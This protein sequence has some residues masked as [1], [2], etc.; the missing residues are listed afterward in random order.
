MSVNKMPEQ[1]VFPEKHVVDEK[2]IDSPPSE[3]EGIVKNWDGEEST[4][5]RK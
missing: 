3:T 2:V 5:K 1:D 4:V